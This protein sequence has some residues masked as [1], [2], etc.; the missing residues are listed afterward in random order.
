MKIKV[1]L[2]YLRMAPRKVR[3]IADLIRG[4]PVLEARHQLMFSPKRAAVPILKLLLS[5]Q[6]Q[7]KE[8]NLDSKNFYISKI[9][10]DGGPTFKRPRL[11]SRGQMHIVRKRTS[12]INLELEE[13]TAKQK[14]SKKEQSVGE[15]EKNKEGIKK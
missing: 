4:L 3:K 1:S 10:V 8:K 14:Q 5:A 11:H 7:L 15:V 12:H 9:T 6:A 13:M 2:K